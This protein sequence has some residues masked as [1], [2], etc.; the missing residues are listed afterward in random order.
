MLSRGP[1]LASVTPRQAS[2]AADSCL[3][4][5]DLLS[6]LPCRGF[7]PDCGCVYSVLLRRISLWWVGCVACVAWELLMNSVLSHTVVEGLACH[8]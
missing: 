7:Q 3:L 8:T 6:S 2:V 4:C 5:A 1:C